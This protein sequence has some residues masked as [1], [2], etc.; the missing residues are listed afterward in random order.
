MFSGLRLASAFLCSLTLGLPSDGTALVIR[1]APGLTLPIAR[2]LNITGAANILKL[3]QARA[4]ALYARPEANTA[5]QKLFNV[6]A[7]DQA[8]SYVANVGVGTP[9]KNFS[10]IIDTGSSNTWV[11]AQASNRY[12]PF[13]SSTSQYQFNSV[14]VTYGSGG[15]IGLEYTDSVTLGGTTIKHQGIGSAILSTGFNG[16]DGILGIGPVGLTKGTLFPA[17]TQTIPTVTDNAYSQGFIHARKVGISFEPTTALN[18][19]NG[20]I[21]F[22][23]VD[24]T[25][26]IAPLNFVPITSTAPAKNYV[27][28]DQSITYGSAGTPILSQT[29]GIIDTGTTLILIASDA[30]ARYQT[31]TGGVPDSTTGLLTITPLQFASLQSLFFHI[32][33]TTYELTPNAQIW[34]RALNSAIGGTPGNIYLIVNNLGTPTGRGLD[35]IDGLTFLQRFYHVYDTDNSEV[36]LATT[37]FTHAT[38]N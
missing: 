33:G 27:G 32:G 25:K 26:F 24:A 35:F 4:Q 23:G 10:L 34:P 12:N 3:D 38:S 36:G 20:E 7:I 14:S 22:G 19:A 5:M 21:T 6:P 11:G 30:F 18:N 2:R 29:A 37:A 31:A 16:V 15:F 28:I 1:D 13:S 8:V 9:P 17:S